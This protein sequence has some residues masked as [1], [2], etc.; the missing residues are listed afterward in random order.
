MGELVVGDKV[1]YTAGRGT[2]YGVVVGLSVDRKTV[3]VK[4]DKSGNVISKQ[5]SLLQRR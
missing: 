2:A 3:Q 4:N 5:V 1:S